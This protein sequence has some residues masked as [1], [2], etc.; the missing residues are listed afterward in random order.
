MADPMLREQ[1]SGAG[2]AQP[3]ADRRVNAVFV[4]E[5]LVT[6][7]LGLLHLGTH[8]LSGD[9]GTSA[10]WTGKSWDF[11]V[12]GLRHE[13]VN[14]WLYHGFEKLWQGVGDSEAVLRIPSVLAAAASVFV[15]AKL[16]QRLFGSR[17]GIVAGLVFATGA[18]LIQHAQN[19]RGYA[20]LVLLTALA[21]YAFVV[22][23]ESGG[24]GP[25]IAFTALILFG[26]TCWAACGWR[27][28]TMPIGLAGKEAEG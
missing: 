14:M 2:E 28:Q 19:A 12:D 11:L 18:L 17:T 1:T 6:L 8:S 23:I 7:A 20:L 25:W 15:V 27:L 13:D 26:L 16:A 24:L 21:T 5:A 9:E 4:G 22:A 3:A 10:V